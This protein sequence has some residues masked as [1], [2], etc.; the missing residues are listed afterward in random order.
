MT[1]P[2]SFGEYELA[3]GGSLL[4]SEQSSLSRPRQHLGRWRINPLG[5][6]R[7]ELICDIEGQT[8]VNLL[9][10]LNN[11]MLLHEKSNAKW[12]RR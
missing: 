3:P 4:F 2:T 8:Y 9:R 10:A 12:S 1:D 6:N 5:S 7:F 11:E